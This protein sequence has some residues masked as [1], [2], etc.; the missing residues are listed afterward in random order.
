MLWSTDSNVA[1]AELFKDRA[2]L[3]LTYS[4]RTVS[5]RET[6]VLVGGNPNSL[7]TTWKDNAWHIVR[8]D[9]PRWAT[10]ATVR[11]GELILVGNEKGQ[12]YTAI[13]AL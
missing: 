3:E 10:S 11:D 8:D 9:L 12:L 2:G 4:P 5:G 1:P 13:E 6:W 7:I